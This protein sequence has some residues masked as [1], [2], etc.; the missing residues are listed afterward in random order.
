VDSSDYSLPQ[1]TGLLD[2]NEALFCRA[3]GP[4][5]LCHKEMTRAGAYPVQVKLSCPLWLLSQWEEMAVTELPCH[6]EVTVVELLTQYEEV[7]VAELAC[8]LKAT[9]VVVT[10][11][12]AQYEEII[13]AELLVEQEW[14]VHVLQVMT[15]M[16]DLIVYTA[17]VV[18]SVH[19]RKIHVSSTI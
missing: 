7:A 10:E 6:L 9:G 12:L 16:F 14:Q 15:S 17:S 13:V 19:L 5:V 2:L 3:L 11:L 4:R 8:R 1:K 18:I